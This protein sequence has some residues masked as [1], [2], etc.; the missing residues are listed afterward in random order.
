MLKSTRLL[1]AGTLRRSGRVFELGIVFDFE[2][3]RLI[4]ARRIVCRRW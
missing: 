2:F 4:R 1:C 3:E